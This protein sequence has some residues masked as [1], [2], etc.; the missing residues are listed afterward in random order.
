MR[1]R[2]ASGIMRRLGLPEL[3]ATSKDDFI[4]SAIR[5]AADVGRCQELKIEVASRRSLLFNDLE[6]VRAL[7]RC[8]TAARAAL[9]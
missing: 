8:L 4:Q 7:E 5:L 2:L 3:V 6:P 1:G 9:G